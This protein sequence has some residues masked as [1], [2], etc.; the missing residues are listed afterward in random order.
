MTAL[1]ERANKVELGMSKADVS[2]NEARRFVEDIKREQDS[3]SHQ[4]S[5]MNLESQTHTS[6]IQDL[7]KAIRALTADAEMR[8]ALDEREIEFLWAAPSH[9]YGSHGWRPN[10]GSKSERTPYPAGN[11]KM[12]VRHGSEGHARDVLAQRRKWLNSITVGSRAAD[13]LESEASAAGTEPEGVPIRLPDIDEMKR[14]GGPSSRA[15]SPQS[16]LLEPA[17]RLLSANPPTL[18]GSVGLSAQPPSATRTA[19]AQPSPTRHRLRRSPSR[20]RR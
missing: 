7:I 6:N 15:D 16:H 11:F 10:N 14:R 1:F 2:V 17:H 9:I 12:A 4:Q 8:A 13:A 19:H 18:G 5:A 3:L 20:Q